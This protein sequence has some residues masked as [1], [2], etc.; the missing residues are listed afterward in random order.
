MPINIKQKETCC[1]CTACQQICPKHCITM[2]QDEEGF[3]YPKPSPNQ[4]VDCG[5]CEK[6]CPKINP[7]DGC[8]PLG[9]YAAKNKEQEIRKESSS[10]GIFSL[11]AD[12]VLAQD[13]I[14][15]GARFDEN[16]HVIMD[17]TDK[18]EDLKKFRGSKYV[19]CDIGDSYAQV[20]HFLTIG[21]KVLY[22]GSSCQIAGLRKYLRHDYSNLLLVDY[23]CHGAPSPLLWEKYLKE[24]SCQTISSLANISFRSKKRGWK[25]F[26][27]SIKR[28]NEILVDQIFSDNIYMK[29]FL[30]DMSL[31]PSCYHCVARNGHSGSD[32]TIGDHWAMRDIDS[33]FDDD[34]GV[35]LVLINTA[36][37]ANVFGK[38]NVTC[39]QTDFE[40]SKKWNGAFYERTEEH[41]HRKRFFRKLQYR[42]DVSA[43][44]EDELNINLWDHIKKRLLKITKQK[45]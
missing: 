43:L 35:S 1:G 23:L 42:T 26:S 14:V 5:L 30:A 11:I 45:L 8:L 16:W 40:T 31:R 28:G 34:E 17:Y 32:I 13:G 36:K 27:V 39:K 4:C 22:T 24:V 6:V 10:G 41:L 2:V 29:A 9:C 3:L 37:G 38:L 19:K 18:K 25:N 33:S 20:K 15:F 44:I 21:R 7:L 12:Y